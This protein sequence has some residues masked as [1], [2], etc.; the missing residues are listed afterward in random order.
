MIAKVFTTSFKNFC[1][2]NIT[3]GC[4]SYTN[5]EISKKEMQKIPF[6]NH[7]KN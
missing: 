3:I 6:K 5:N 4:I 1:T 7:T 2:S